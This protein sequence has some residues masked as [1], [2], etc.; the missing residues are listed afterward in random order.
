MHVTKL[1]WCDF[2]IW[3]PVQEPFVQRVKYD[4]SF[5]KTT[6]VKA[7]K[8]YFEKFLPSVLPC[9]LITPDDSNT[10]GFPTT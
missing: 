2:V 8:F 9:M 4:F 7:R 10:W 3:S 6:L 5:M 1:H